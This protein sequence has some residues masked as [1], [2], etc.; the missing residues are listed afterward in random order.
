MGLMVF[1]CVSPDSVFG[2]VAML[3]NEAGANH[4]PSRSM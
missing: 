2:T 3:T 1:H 4:T